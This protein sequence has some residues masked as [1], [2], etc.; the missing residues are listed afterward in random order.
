MIPARL[1]MYFPYGKISK[2]FFFK[3]GVFYQNYI[4]SF[5]R[6]LPINM[7]SFCLPPQ[8]YRRKDSMVSLF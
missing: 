3:G 4:S 7:Q 8:S 6:K 1:Y 5:I 2:K